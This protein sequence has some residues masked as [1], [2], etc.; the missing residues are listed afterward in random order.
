[1][2]FIYEPHSFAPLATVQQGQTFG[3]HCDQIGVPLELT[4]AVRV[5]T[6]VA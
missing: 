4:D 2:L 5:K 6:V 1:V 3:Y